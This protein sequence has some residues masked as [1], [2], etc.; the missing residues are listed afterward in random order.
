MN[1]IDDNQLREWIRDDQ[2]ILTP[3][4]VCPTPIIYGDCRI[5]KMLQI[6]HF[7]QECNRTKLPSSNN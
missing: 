2:V 4:D 7:V 5:E 1:K 6:A 3:S